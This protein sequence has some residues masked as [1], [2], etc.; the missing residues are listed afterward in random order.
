MVLQ[1]SKMTSESAESQNFWGGAEMLYKSRWDLPGSESD[2]GACA[3]NV[4]VNEE[5]D[6]VKKCEVCKLFSKESSAAFYCVEC[7]KYLCRSCSDKHLK[8]SIAK[9]HKIVNSSE[10]IDTQTNCKQHASETLKYF[11]RTCKIP[12]CIAC[13]FTDEHPDHDIVDLV[14]ESEDN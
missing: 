2:E 3:N 13:T 5:L 7:T 1:D 9:G 14:D 11:C 12:L 4:V 6:R 8:T 10:A